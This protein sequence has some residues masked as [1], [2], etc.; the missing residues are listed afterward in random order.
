M[1]LRKSID[2]FLSQQ[3]LA[4]VGV[5]RDAKQFANLAYRLLKDRRYQVYPVN[6]NAGRLE[7]D[8]CYPNIQSLPQ[9]VDAALVVLPPEKTMKVISEIADAGIKHVWFQQ[10]TES[11]ETIRFCQDRNINVISGE[12]IIMY[13]EPLA[14]PHRLHRWVKKVTGSYPK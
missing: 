7:N 13:L 3:K 10:G 1:V 12:C 8:R 6:P 2:D 14:I 4:V 5:S 11:T 9:H